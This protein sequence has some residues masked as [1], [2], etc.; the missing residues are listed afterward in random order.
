MYLNYKLRH[1]RSKVGMKTE[2]ILKQLGQLFQVTFL[3]QKMTKNQSRFVFPSIESFDIFLL[4]FQ[5]W[6]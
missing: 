3:C 4:Q 2:C 5:L 6:K 1:W